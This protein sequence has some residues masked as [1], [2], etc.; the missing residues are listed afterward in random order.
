M[1]IPYIGYSNCM[2]IGDYQKITTSCGLCCVGMLI[3]NKKDF[4]IIKELSLGFENNGIN[5]NG[6][7]HFYLLEI[8]KKY[9][10]ESERKEFNSYSKGIEYIINKI[11][12]EEAVVISMIKS[13]LNQTYFH[14]V[15]ILGYRF[16]EKGEL[17]RFYYHDPASPDEISGSFL[18]MEKSQFIKSWRKITIG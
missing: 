3:K 7:S 14:M 13:F 17:V 10:I 12:K 5:S 4:D 16:D 6:W 11:D 8:L 18:Y 9:S 15:L 1:E 2:E